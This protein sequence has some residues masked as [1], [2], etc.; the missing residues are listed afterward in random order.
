M[1]AVYDLDRAV[2]SVR[3]REGRTVV[4]TEDWNTPNGTPNGGY[5]LAVLLH[6]MGEEA[7]MPDPLTVAISYFRPPTAGPARIEVTPLRDGRRIAT[8]QAALLQ[9][10]RIVA[11]A[12]ASFHD[13]EAA[14]TAEPET[15]GPVVP[16]RS[17]RTAPAVPSPEHC[18]DP[19]SQIPPGAVPITEK[20]RYRH[21][22]IPGWMTGSPTGA[23]EAL[24]WV[25]P[26]DG[27]PVDALAAAVI[28]DAY[29]PVTT[30]IGELRSAT[31]QLTVT[32][33]RRPR[34]DWLLS[35]IVCRHVVDGYHD[36]DVELWDTD[37]RIVAEGRQV[38]IMG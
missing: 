32:F 9:Q 2:R 12:T 27:R 31:V 11:H 5:L 19:M 23:T 10:D 35:H 36:E 22:E 4:L 7:P 30:E 21:P 26:A 25:R 14:V 6:A 29:P 28:V 17:R 13:A 20:F 18:H 3:D 8:L 37:G 34:T 38:A 15:T 33:R 16:H 1:E 24:F